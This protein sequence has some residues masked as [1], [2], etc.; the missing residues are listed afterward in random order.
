[1]T[2]E[3]Q[4]LGAAVLLLLCVFASKVTGKLGVPTLVVFLGIGILAGSEGLGGFYF[5]DPMAMQSLG[6]VSLSYIL[7]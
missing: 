5:N 2:T 1:M 6:I 7:F 4:M 3:T